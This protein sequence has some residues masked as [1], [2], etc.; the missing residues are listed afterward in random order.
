MAIR[1][2]FI[3]R[4]MNSFLWIGLAPWK[5]KA[6]GF[7][8]SSGSTITD[9]SSRNGMAAGVEDHRFLVYDYFADFQ[10]F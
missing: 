8:R 5:P 7:L 4:F 9:G 6:I 10:D 1:H 2:F 3:Y